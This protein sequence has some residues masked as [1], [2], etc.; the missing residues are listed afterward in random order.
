[1]PT[2]P[3]RRAFRAAVLVPVSLLALFLAGCFS[4]TGQ[5]TSQVGVVGDVVVTT[6]MCVTN[7][8]PP[9][10]CE[11][12]LSQDQAADDQYFVGYLVEDWVTA[13]ATIS[14]SGTLGSLSLARS[15][16]YAAALA[17]VLSPGTGRHWIGYASGRQPLLHQA[18]DYRMTAS[19]RLGLWHHGALDR[20]ADQLHREGPRRRQ[21]CDHVLH[22]EF[23]AGHSADD[24]DGA[25]EYPGDRAEHARADGVRCGG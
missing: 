22:R 13:P 20:T 21:R 12:G 17:T 25:G 1:M 16:A 8:F 15:D 5:T 24:A 4:I 6:E 2:R 18:T 14:W 11:Q 10:P 7:P 19:A 9:G 3:S 23:A